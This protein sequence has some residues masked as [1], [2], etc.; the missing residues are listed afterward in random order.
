MK[1]HVRLIKHGIALAIA[2]ALA[3]QALA[4]DSTAS[5]KDV[6]RIS[7]V[8]H[9][10]AYRGDVPVKELPQSVSIVTEELL[11]NM[12]VMDLQSALRFSSGIASQN[13]FGGLWDSFAIRGF[14]GDG[15][16]PSGYLVNGFNT[17]RGFTGKRDVS[18]I[19]AIEILK[20]PGSA[21]YGR[22]EPGGTINIV[23]KKPQFE[24]EGYLEATAGS[25]DLY[26]LEG[27]YTNAIN[28]DFAFRVNG[29]YEN[30][31]SFRDTVD[32]K[33]TFLT[34][35]LVYALNPD[36]SVFYE[37]EYIDQEADFDRG[38]AI[39]DMQFGVV[40]IDTFYGEPGDGPMSIEGLAHQLTIQ[41]NLNANWSINSGIS[42]RGSSFEGYSTEPELSAG[43]QL[44]LV[45]GETLSRQR[46]Y[47]DYDTT[48]LSAR[49]EL[50]GE[51]KTAGMAHHLLI[52]ADA[53]D[54]DYKELMQRWRT[55]WGGGDPTY[56]VDLLNPQYGAEAPAMGI[57]I[58]TKE[59]QQ[60]YGVYAQDQIDL[61]T[62]LKM[63]IGLRFDDFEQ[64]VTNLSNGV[65]TSQA[66]TAISPRLGAVY[67]PGNNWSLYLSYSE[68]FSPNSGVDN[69]GNAFEPEESKSYEG[70]VKFN[71]DNDSVTGTLAV[72]RAEKSNILAADPV[73]GG[74]IAMGEVE[75][76]GVELD[77]TATVYDDT[78]V[79]MSYAYVDAS[80]SNT[81]T[82][83]DWGVEITAGTPLVNIPEHTF[84]LNARHDFSLG[85]YPTTV[86]AGLTF[87]DERVGD[88]VAPDY[89]LPG[90]T[91]VNV[92]GVVELT[93]QLTARLVI[94]NLFDKEYYDN[95]YSALWTQP[96]KPLNAR[97]SLRYLF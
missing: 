34:P 15:N 64:H 25:F 74:T 50:S 6:E 19:Q 44:L 61:A 65:V 7:I 46:R 3:P 57:V 80:N 62:S 4:Q 18:S 53:Y 35:S 16:K 96:G 1:Q 32:S 12:G 22:G 30:A 41:T 49:F 73:N 86:S 31:G 68:G 8:K 97:A 40:P 33:K 78:V 72:F 26:R 17:G 39:P 84:T 13:N 2:V 76:S 52:G 54:Y 94:D 87:V 36:T 92:S 42:L 69:N 11:D 43:R 85:G 56:S 77:I 37:L 23:T 71:T 27:D 91:I 90:Y 95:S 29:A 66:Q 88:A 63:L 14:A 21:L 20:G 82:N 59:E 28:S 81:V 93:P 9:R 70:G 55:N 48:D 83:P 24:Q 5:D 89:K 58:N 75:S 38:I 79:I 51:I 60:A 10:Q 45:D 67:L 47:R